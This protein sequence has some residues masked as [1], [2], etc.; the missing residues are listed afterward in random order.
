MLESDRAGFVTS[1]QHNWYRTLLCEDVFKFAPEAREMD[2]GG[3]D[4]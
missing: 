2:F 1:L 4:V 3:G